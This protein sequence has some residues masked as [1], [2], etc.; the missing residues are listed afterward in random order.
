MCMGLVGDCLLGTAGSAGTI[1]IFRCPIVICRKCGAGRNRGIAPP[2]GMHANCP[3]HAKE[4]AKIH[5]HA[6]WARF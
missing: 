3:V 5:A 1:C 2:D 6:D 4:E